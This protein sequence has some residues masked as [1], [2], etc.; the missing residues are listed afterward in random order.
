MS[1]AGEHECILSP[2]TTARVAGA[3]APTVATTLRSDFTLF[4]CPFEGDDTHGSAGV[5]STEQEST[6]AVL[7]VASNETD[8]QHVSAV[9]GE[10]CEVTREHL[11]RVESTLSLGPYDFIRDVVD[12]TAGCAFI[13]VAKHVTQPVRSR[14]VPHGDWNSFNYV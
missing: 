4:C 5:S 2:Q 1:S 12:T 14:I 8:G 9:T 6:C 10:V 11:L 13:F 7:T 3:S